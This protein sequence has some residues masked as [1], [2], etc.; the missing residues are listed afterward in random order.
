MFGDCVTVSHP[1]NVVR[2]H[3]GL[4]GFPRTA[5]AR[6]EL[7]GHPASIRDKELEQLTNYRLRPQRH[8][9]FLLVRVKML[10]EEAL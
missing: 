2:H 6:S 4:L 7:A 5:C 10:V 1:G 3:P 8:R 9:E